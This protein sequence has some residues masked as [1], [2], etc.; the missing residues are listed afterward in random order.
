MTFHDQVLT[1]FEVVQSKYYSLSELENMT[2]FEWEIHLG[3]LVQRE[4]A[5]EKAKAGR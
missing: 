5:K 4:E 1:N 2:P 3:L